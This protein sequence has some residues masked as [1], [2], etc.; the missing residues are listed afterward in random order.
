[1]KS[2]VLIDD[3]ELAHSGMRL[4]LSAHPDYELTD[5]FNQA[6][7]G[8]AHLE[9]RGAD[10]VL[11]DLELPD[12][13]GATI[14]PEISGRLGIPVIVVTGVTIPAV[15]RECEEKGAM[16][17]VSKGDPVDETLHAIEA[18]GR[19][20]KYLSAMV[21]RMFEEQNTEGAVSMSGRQKEILQMLSRGLSNKEISYRL[22]IAQPTV[23]FH[24]AEIRRKLGARHSRQLVE[25]GRAAGLV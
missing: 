16:G 14:L 3:H 20:Q 8:L 17:I 5:C 13:G 7:T 10:L 15:L 19:G 18:V 2:V 6:K 9:D 11:L 25:L 24:L 1:M 23:S 4:L 12:A 22:G 21:R